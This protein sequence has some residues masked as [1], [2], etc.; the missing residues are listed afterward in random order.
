MAAED[1]EEAEDFDAEEGQR[2]DVCCGGEAG[3]E[4][5]G[6]HEGCVGGEGC[7][8]SVW[9]EERILVSMYVFFGGRKERGIQQTLLQLLRRS[10]RRIR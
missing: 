6:G 4:D 5:C 3:G 9:G 2:E 10:R 8:E 1:G 7:G